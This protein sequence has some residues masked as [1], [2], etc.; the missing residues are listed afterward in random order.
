MK[1]LNYNNE[2]VKILKP[3]LTNK[4]HAILDVGITEKVDG[5]LTIDYIDEA[6][7]ARRIVI[8]YNDLGEW[9]ESHTLIKE[10]T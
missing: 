7:E 8:G 5:G 9:V 4:N 6:I 3:I 10:L 2:V 1:K